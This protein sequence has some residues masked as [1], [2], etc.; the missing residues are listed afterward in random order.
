MMLD[1]LLKHSPPF[2]IGE[3]LL[4]L[5]LALFGVA[6]IGTLRD[7]YSIRVPVARMR[8]GSPQ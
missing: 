5:S 2:L 8:D 7:R 1:V 3:L 6:L 4:A